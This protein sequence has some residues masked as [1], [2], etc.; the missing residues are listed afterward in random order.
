MPQHTLEY[1]N[2]PK[3]GDYKK[4][5]MQRWPDE[6]FLTK[7]QFDTIT[8]QE[9]YYCGKEGPNGIDRVNNTQGYKVENC[10]AACKHCN[11][12]K[13]DLSLEDFNTW[14]KR[15]VLKQIKII[16]YKEN[17]CSLLPTTFL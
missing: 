8:S 12:V 11:Y 16:K 15:F 17:S 9:C 1:K 13:G 14:R 2:P 7:E 10:V 6:P 3:Y 5:A 4:R